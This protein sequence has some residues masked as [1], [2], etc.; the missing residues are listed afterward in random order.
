MYDHHVRNV[1]S[2]TVGL[3]PP[4]HARCGPE[5]GIYGPYQADPAKPL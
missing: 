5:V 2:L 4:D 1:I 3:G